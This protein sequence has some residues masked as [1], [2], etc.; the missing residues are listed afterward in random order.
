MLISIIGI[1]NTVARIAI[2][3]IAD[4]SWADS[5]LING[6]ALVIGGAVTM[7]FTYFKSYAMMVTY[8]AVFGIS[9]GESLFFQHSIFFFFFFFFFTNN[10]AS[11][12]T[13]SINV[14]Y[15]NARD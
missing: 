7:I 4:R 3:W 12:L 9:I 6:V 1:F 2:G 14:C 13:Y 5:V 10:V 15:R 11:P 8:A